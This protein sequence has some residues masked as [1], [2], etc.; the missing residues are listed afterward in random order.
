MERK[1]SLSKRKFGLDLMLTKREE[2]TKASIVLSIIAMKIDR[3]AAMLLRFFQ[4]MLYFGI[5]HNLT[6][7]S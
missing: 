5:S 2:N 3:L 7:N 4:I 6:E 1:L